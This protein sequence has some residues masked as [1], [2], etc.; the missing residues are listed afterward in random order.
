MLMAAASPPAP[1]DPAGEVEAFRKDREARLRAPDG[2]LSLVGLSWLHPGPNRFGSA[3][4]DEVRM[5]APVPSHAGTLTVDGSGVRASIAAGVT[6]TLNG[7]R[8]EATA[9]VPL[10]SDAREATPDVLAIGDVTLQ[11][12]DR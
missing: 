8:W 4:D 12:I 9:P 3:P 7:R 2:W 11:V 1:V 5:P 10:R 6:A